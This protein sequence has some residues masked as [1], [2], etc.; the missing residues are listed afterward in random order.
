MTQQTQKIS[1]R[2][3]FLLWAG[4]LAASAGLLKMLPFSSRKNINAALPGKKM[5]AQDGT[6]VE[7]D[8]RY[9]GS[10]GKK[11]SKE[12]LQNWIKK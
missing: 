11:V 3:K 5:L 6:L 2:K 7:I 12:E 10:A 8:P 1:S 9:I 4:T